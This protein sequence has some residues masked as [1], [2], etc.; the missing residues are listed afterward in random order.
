MI[1]NTKGFT[2]IELMVVILIIGILAALAIPKFTNASAKAKFAEA[3]TVLAAWQ[4]AQIARIAETG[5]A[6]AVGDLVFDAPNNA[7]TKWIDYRER[8][9]S[10]ANNRMYEGFASTK[11][12]SFAVN[13]DVGARALDDGT[14][15]HHSNNIA[16]VEQFAP[17]FDAVAW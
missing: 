13:D 6:G 12:G 17:N 16:A 2:L 10:A 14:I 11:I 7:E 1:R 4:N 5:L 3:P 9:G 8:A 15:T